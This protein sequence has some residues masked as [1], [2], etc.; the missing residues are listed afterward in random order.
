MKKVFLFLSFCILSFSTYSQITG[1]SIDYTCLGN[2]RYELRVNFQVPCGSTVQV[3]NIKIALGTDTLYADSVQLLNITQ[4]PD[5]SSG[6]S[7]LDSCRIDSSAYRM[8]IH[9]FRGV[10]DLDTFSACQIRFFIEEATGN[11]LTTLSSR[12][13]IYLETRTNRCLVPCNTSPGQKNIFRSL[14]PYNIDFRDSHSVTILDTASSYKYS[15]APCRETATQPV[16]YSGNFSKDRWLTFLGF[17]NQTLQWP[18]GLRIDSLTGILLF[19]PTQIGQRSAVCVKVQHLQRINGKDTLIGEK[20]IE[21]TYQTISPDSNRTP[22]YTGQASRVVC[23]GETL[24]FDIVTTDPNTQDSVFLELLDTLPGSS[25]SIQGGQFPV[26]TICW[27]PDSSFV[28]AQPYIVH[29]RV[30][31]NG[32]PVYLERSRNYSVTVR[33]NPLFSHQITQTGSCNQVN[34]DL[35]PA[36]NYP[37]LSVLWTIQDSARNP[38]QNGI[39]LHYQTVLKSGKYFITLQ[40]SG[41]NLCNVAVLDSFIVNGN[42]PDVTL[43]TRIRFGCVGEE[44][45]I[46]VLTA[47]GVYQYVW[48]DGNTDSLRIITLGTDTPKYA[49]TIING[50]CSITDTFRIFPNTPPDLTRTAVWIAKDSLKL[51]IVNPVVGLNYLWY[52]DYSPTAAGITP[53]LTVYLDDSIHHFIR[54]RASYPNCSAEDSFVVSPATGWRMVS[55]TSIQIYPNPFSSSILIDGKDIQSVRMFNAL[56]QEMRIQLKSGEGKTEVIP[57]DNLSTGVYWL[58]METESGYFM[59]KV[60]KE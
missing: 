29:T 23:A 18:A 33:Q 34:F 43:S 42:L 39:G 56:G 53:Q 44:D 1:G 28:S 51:S 38:I 37:G 6:C 4:L 35:T 9:Q 20:W 24:C 21:H 31:D 25:I 48:H 30:R 50:P 32:C 45:T 41:T 5:I 19:R 14:L 15:F 12:S 22:G 55:E 16:S 10:V 17:P 46:G 13:S 7:M 8:Y 60:V 52:I 49:L 2:S 47:K 27:T 54:V 36:Q 3:P 58:M 26:A 59:E 40:L 11:F 57:M